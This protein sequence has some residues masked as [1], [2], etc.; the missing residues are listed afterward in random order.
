MWYDSL[1]ERIRKLELKFND[2]CAFSHIYLLDRA[3]KEQLLEEIKLIHEYLGVE[4]VKQ[5]TKLVKKGEG[6]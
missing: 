5:S 4:K 3:D 2:H 6:K 1:K